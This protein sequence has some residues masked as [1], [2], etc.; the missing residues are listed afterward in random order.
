LSSSFGTF[1]VDDVYPIDFESPEAN[2]H[3]FFAFKVPDKKSADEQFLYDEF[4]IILP[5][6]IGDLADF[7]NV[8]GTIV[9]GGRGFYLAL[10]SVP[11]W[12]KEQSSALFEVEADRCTKTEDEFMIHMNRIRNDPDRVFHTFLFLL[13]EGMAFSDDFTTMNATPSASDCNRPVLIRE[14]HVEKAIGKSQNIIPQ[15]FF[16]GHFIMRILRCNATSKELMSA[17]KE[18]PDFTA[19]FSGMKMTQASTPMRARQARN[20]KNGTQGEQGDDG[21]TSMY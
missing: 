7:S 5:N 19:A 12:M 10:P 13:P 18:A 21:D 8:K 20:K 17:S 1:T 6:G 11:A 4:K 2:G 15:M 16:P 3:G 14:V 9:L